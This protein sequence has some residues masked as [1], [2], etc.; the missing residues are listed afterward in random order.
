[1]RFSAGQFLGDRQA[2][3]RFAGIELADMR[4]TVPRHEVHAHT[5]DE[6]HL[7]VLHR[8]E[9]LAAGPPAGLTAAAQCASL[10]EAFLKLTGAPQASERE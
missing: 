8:G 1:M 6:A 9:L 7:L 3:R 2:R 10:S 5:H 4:P